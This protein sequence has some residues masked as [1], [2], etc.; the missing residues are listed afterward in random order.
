MSFHLLR[1]FSEQKFID[2]YFQR[3]DGH[4]SKMHGLPIY[5][6]GRLSVA[7]VEDLVCNTCHELIEFYFSEMVVEVK[8]M[9]IFDSLL[10]GA[11]DSADTLF[12]GNLRRPSCEFY[13]CLFQHL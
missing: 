5:A 13:A 7:G 8:S 4:A 2:L 1:E 6:F 9:L 3:L 12:V 10:A 11:K